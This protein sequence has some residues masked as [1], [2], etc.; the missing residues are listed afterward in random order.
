MQGLP[1]GAPIDSQK[2][3]EQKA[4][5][6]GPFAK[7]DSPAPHIPPTAAPPPRS[8]VRSYVRVTVACRAVQGTGTKIG[9]QKWH[10]Q[11]AGGSGIFTKGSINN[12]YAPIEGVRDDLDGQLAQFAAKPGFP[13]AIAQLKKL[14][15]RSRETQASMAIALHKKHSKRGVAN[16]KAVLSRLKTGAEQSASQG[17]SVKAAKIHV[18]QMHK[19]KCGG[20]SPRL[21]KR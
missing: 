11:K 20:L 4:G 2:Y 15:P 9:S 19:Q 1:A 10:E 17:P 6:Y 21:K 7:V 13:T 16:W 5:A 8:F 12:Y 18:M 3:H 14:P